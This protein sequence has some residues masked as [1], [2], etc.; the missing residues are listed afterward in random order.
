[1]KRVL[2]SVCVALALPA[3]AQNQPAK[4]ANSKKT[5]APAKTK[6][7][8][9]TR[10]ALRTCFKQQAANGVENTAIS[11]EK[12][13][14]QQERNDIVTAKEA[15]LKKS[16]ELGALVADIE[17]EGAKLMAAQKEFEQPVAKADL[18]AVEARRVEFNDG[19]TAHQRKIDVYNAEKQPFNTSKDALDARIAANNTRGKALQER[20]E[21]YNEAV[22][23][24][25]A[26]CSNKPYDVADEI[27]IKKELSAAGRP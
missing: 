10:D 16:N 23:E 25:K 11:T 17:A 12:D 8:V 26:N 5:A 20:S 15:L 1:M 21:K 19:V 9:M 4:P 24:W 14:F 27:A 3:M 22:D 18:K 6:T 7:V 2:I 13:A